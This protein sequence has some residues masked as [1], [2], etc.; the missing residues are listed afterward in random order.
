[1]CGIAGII[2]PH[3]QQVS[4]EQ[5]KRMTQSLAHRG[6]DGE[7]HWISPSGQAG[8]GHRRLAII[9]LSDAAAQPMPYQ[10]RYTIVHNGEIYNYIELRE[11]LQKKGYSFS[12]RSDTE[13]LLAAYDCWKEDCLEKLDGM[14]AF[15]IWDE[16][17][18]ILFAARDRFGEK[19]FYF[20]EPASAPGHQQFLFAS[21]MKALWAAG[22]HR[23]PD[24]THLLNYLALGY[25]GP[26]RSS[27]HT[28]YKN[29]FQLPPAHYLRLQLHPSG[30]AGYEW[31]IK[32]Y[33][34][35]NRQAVSTDT[36]DTARETFRH[37]LTRSVQ[38]RMRSDVPIGTSLSGGIDSSSI[39]ALMH[40]LSAPGAVLNTFSAVFPG[41]EKDESAWIQQVT[42]RF[43]PHAFRVEPGAA[44]FAGELDRLIHYHEVPISSASV[45][46]QYKVF[47]L[48]REQQVKVLLDGQ[49]ADE[50]LAGYAKYAHWHLQEL[51][52]AGQSRQVVKERELLQQNGVPFQWDWKNQ[53]AARF[54]RKAARQLRRRETARLQHDPFINPDFSNQYFDRNTIYKP[55]ITGLNDILSYNTQENGLEELLRNADRNSMAHGREVRLPFLS[56]ELVEYVF[57]LPSQYKIREGWTKWLLRTTMESELPAAITWRKDK[58]GF[59][60]PQKTWMED[61]QVQELVLEAKKSLVKEK[62]LVP[63]VLHKKIQPLD[64]HAADNFDW[65]WLVAA[66]LL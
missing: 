33:W 59:E 16:W 25:T 57:S 28:F 54:P 19:P 3:A 40:R 66:R 65:R 52:A 24:N 50:I 6:P 17:K 64:T 60:P 12:T 13:V 27:S 11:E 34:T 58:T 42:D 18:K 37:L 45:Y 49:G 48:A 21:E 51:L 1:M 47:E 10:D 9:D 55:V 4:R 31:T 35:I 41:Y 38:R 15:A 43:T 2:S 5:L 26:A 39:L 63:E 61:G 8:L 7:A 22:H 30:Q 62:I 32:R 53:V 20:C 56:H 14:F 44:G 36:A 29:T 23:Q 46:A